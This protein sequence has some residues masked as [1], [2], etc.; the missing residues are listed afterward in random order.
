MVAS[1]VSKYK[2]PT[3]ISI[4][5]RNK[6]VESHMGLAR[7]IAHKWEKKTHLPYEE[8]EAVAFMHLVGTVENFDNESGNA[9]SSYA[10]PRLGGRI[11]NTVRDEGFTVRLPR[12]Y[13]DLIQKSKRF[14]RKLTKELGR[15]PTSVEL[16]FSMGITLE[17]LSESRLAL[18]S[19]KQIGRDDATYL[20][21]YN[22]PNKA[23]IEYKADWSAL[24][25]WEKTIVRLYLRDKKALKKLNIT[26]LELTKAIAIALAKIKVISE[27]DVSFAA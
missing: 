18:S 13:Y 6:V 21:K 7:F 16:A 27:V 20:Q 14:E 26:K 22:S 10:V 25:K 24:S 12:P 8:I 23:Q 19:C 17:K 11:V 5:E 3:Y 2:K 1:T 15:R 4:K 9:F